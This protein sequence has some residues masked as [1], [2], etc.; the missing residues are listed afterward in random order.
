MAA[1]LDWAGRR[2]LPVLKNELI[3]HISTVHA[4]PRDSRWWLT[5][6]SKVNEV[7]CDEAPATAWTGVSL[8]DCAAF[9]T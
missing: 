6:S 4:T 7:F 1:T 5:G 2:G 8:D 3:N 9:L